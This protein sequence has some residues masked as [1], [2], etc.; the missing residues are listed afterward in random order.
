MPAATA[1]LSSLSLLLFLSACSGP[2]SEG[3]HDSA[4]AELIAQ[5]AQARQA[6]DLERALEVVEKA[7]RLAPDLP[8]VWGEQG[9]TCYAIATRNQA[10]GRGGLLV[11][12]YLHDARHSLEKAVHAGSQDS[13]TH[14]LL[15]QILREAGLVDQ[16][17][18]R[19]TAAVGL[20]GDQPAKARAHLEV[21][22]VYNLRLA[23]L[24]QA[25]DGA[26]E[27]KETAAK[28]LPHLDRATQLAP[29]DP[30]AWLSLANLFAWIQDPLRIQEVCSAGASTR[31]PPRRRSTWPTRTAS[32]A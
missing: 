5:A 11:S 22:R 24:S 4:A 10:Q 1:L 26:G 9:R 14:R 12:G 23:Q 29:R 8:A 28:A 25:G 19:A 17:L 31:S 13:E 6:G 3:N 15:A 16:A 18:E 7:R 2:N 27:M 20:A 32:S 21:G 30:Q